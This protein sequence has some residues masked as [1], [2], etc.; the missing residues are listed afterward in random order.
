MSSAVP[1]RWLVV[2]TLLLGVA[3]GH[4]ERRPVAVINLDTSDAAGPQTLAA[5]LE[6]ELSAHAVLRVIPDSS[7]AAALRD[8]IDDDD[9][10]RLERARIDLEEAKQALLDFRSFEAVRYTEEGHRE[11]LVVTPAVAVKL[12][13]QLAVVMGTAL[14]DEKRPAESK[15]AFEHALA[16]DP[17]ISPDP[18]YTR[19]DVYAAFRAAAQPSGPP[20]KLE[21][22]GTGVVWIDG[23]EVGL[24]PGTFDAYA[25]GHVVW[26]T[27]VDRETRGLQVMVQAGQTTVAE[28]PDA[29]APRRMKVQRARLL[30]ARA[31]DPTARAAAMKRLADLVGVKDA[32][33]LSLTNG[34]I[35]FQTWSEDAAVP[36][37]GFSAHEERRDREPA[38]LLVRLAPPPPIDDSV[39]IKLPPPPPPKKW[40]QKRSWQLGIAAGVV[41]AVVGGYFLSQAGPDTFIGLGP[42]PRFTSINGVGRR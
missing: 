13:A 40:Y 30:L 5:E 14:F 32:V 15:A 33:L 28:V 20:G 42:D 39:P 1:A 6:R 3:T 19:P 4:A 27:G 8:R 22:K 36:V 16:L 37:P 18:A 41:G 29:E 7:D 25:G 35:T 10:P 21:V 17:G 9:G 31:P 24:A 38:D 26:L 12:Y 2:C 23:N 34:Q 11:L